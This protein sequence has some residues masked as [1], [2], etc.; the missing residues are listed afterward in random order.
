MPIYEYVCRGCGQEFE[1]LVRGDEAPLCPSCGGDK[2]AKKPSVPAAH[3][4]S[5]QPACPAQES[6]ACNVSKCCGRGC[7]VAN[8][9]RLVPG[10]PPAR[11]V[12]AA[13]HAR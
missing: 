9:Q 2:L 12:S 6:G 13:T 7:D 3:T 11:P 8:R 5:S 4:G 10:T 1:W